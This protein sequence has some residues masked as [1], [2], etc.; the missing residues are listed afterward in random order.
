MPSAKPIRFER[1]LL[2]R[3]TR[4]DRS[5]HDSHTRAITIQASESHVSRE[6]VQR[7]AKPNDRPDGTNL[8]LHHR[9][10][11]SIG[12]CP[13]A[14]NVVIPLVGENI[15]PDEELWVL[16]FDN[17]DIV[18]CQREVFMELQ[19]LPLQVASKLPRCAVGYSVVARRPRLV[20]GGSELLAQPCRNKGIR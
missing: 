10:A 20:H 19:D 7:Y 6:A 2:E 1:H 17:R 9:C 15:L 4:L 3:C 13:G 8:Q 11:T 5:C 12:A 14:A 16:R 18:N